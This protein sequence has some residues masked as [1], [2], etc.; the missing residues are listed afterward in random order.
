MASSAQTGVVVV[1]SVNMDVVSAVAEFPR[2][3]ETVKASATAFHSGGK[4][5]NQA[6]AV[7]AATARILRLAPCLYTTLAPQIWLN[8]YCLT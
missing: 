3:G 6:V 4:G 8:C 5:A 7:A 1:G 2:P